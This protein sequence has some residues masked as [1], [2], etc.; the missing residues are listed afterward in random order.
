MYGVVCK[1]VIIRPLPPRLVSLSHARVAANVIII[2]SY[3]NQT[4]NLSY[5][6]M[7]ANNIIVWPVAFCNEK[8]FLGK[9]NLKEA[10]R[11]YDLYFLTKQEK[12][13]CNYVVVPVL[14]ALD[15]TITLFA[16][17]VRN[18]DILWNALL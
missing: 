11:L 5:T 16:T 4:S 18:I 15:F 13:D 3:H 17:K 14:L 10:I 8:R 7:I 6:T 9:T 1:T 2:S 12:Y